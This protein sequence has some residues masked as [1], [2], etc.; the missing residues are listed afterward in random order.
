MAQK[1]KVG[2]PKKM[3]TKLVNV[4]DFNADEEFGLTEMQS[5]FVWHYT[6]GACGQTEAARRA[7]FSFPSQAATKM[8]NGKDQPHVTRAI[9]I[10]Q[11]ELREKY[12]ITPQK[13]GTMLWKIA[14]T[15][16]EAGA[17][18]ASVSAIKELNQLAGLNI[19]RS[20]SLNINANIDKMSKE[21]ITNRL[22]ELLGLK[23][24]ME[25]KDH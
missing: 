13:T 4:P 5:A 11:D 9:R 16:F 25:D 14:E 8:L 2:R 23:D 1:N 18:N 19:H 6:E 12:A 17:Y 22:S 3:H 15:A 21:D 10:A 24:E 20:Q 7:G